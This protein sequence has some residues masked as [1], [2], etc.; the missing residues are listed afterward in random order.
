M[1]TS[2]RVEWETIETA[3]PKLELEPQAL[4]ARC[5]RAA[6]KVNGQIVAELGMGVVA[7]KLGTTWRVHVP[8]V[9]REVA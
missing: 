2:E 8:R 6:R 1:K 3:A 5:R 4:R 9:D 7:K